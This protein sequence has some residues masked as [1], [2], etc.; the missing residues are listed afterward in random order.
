MISV[1]VDVGMSSVFA[2]RSTADYLFGMR[3]SKL[4]SNINS[5]RKGTRV[6]GAKLNLETLHL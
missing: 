6:L 3:K 1:G 5:R 4:K 2:S